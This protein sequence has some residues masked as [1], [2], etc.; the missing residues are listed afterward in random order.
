M[1]KRKLKDPPLLAQP[2]E[3]NWAALSLELCSYGYAKAKIAESVGLTRQ[4]LYSVISGELEPSWAQGELI[5]TWIKME[6]LQ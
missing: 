5:L 6:R 3:H 1:Y 4:Q 2:D